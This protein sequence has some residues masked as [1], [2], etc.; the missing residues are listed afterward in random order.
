[1]QVAAIMTIDLF[2]STDAI[3]SSKRKLRT[4]WV[5]GI[6]LAIALLLVLACFG[7]VSF[8]RLQISG[9]HEA[10]ERDLRETADSLERSAEQFDGARGPG[11][12]WMITAAD[13]RRDAR[14]MREAADRE[15]QLKAK[16]LAGALHPWKGVPPD[17]EPK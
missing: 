16:Y 13:Y 11:S 17:A 9:Q 14:M 3:L 1:M 4:R 12:R 8:V 15:A 6:L 10:R 7:I 2:E 5:V